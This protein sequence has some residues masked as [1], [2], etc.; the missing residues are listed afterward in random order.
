MTK[1]RNADDETIYPAISGPRALQELA[2]DIRSLIEASRFR[3]A[4]T[5]NT[6]LVLL[7]WQIGTRIREDILRQP[8]PNTE[9]KLSLHCR[10]N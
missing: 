7:Y 6:E 4:R 5:V 1:N 9:S 2:A 8:G 10:D 3:A